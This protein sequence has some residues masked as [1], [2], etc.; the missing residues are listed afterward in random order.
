MRDHSLHKCHIVS[1]VTRVGDSNSGFFREE[2][3]HFP[4]GAGRY[5]GWCRGCC[6]QGEQQSD[7][8]RV[9]RFHR[10]TLLSDLWCR[11]SNTPCQSA[12][13]LSA[14]VK[15]NVQFAK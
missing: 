9:K 8:Y 13:R 14:N 1:G 4:G 10:R 15:M 3:G 2:G 7:G 12:S 6:G 11:F 5:N